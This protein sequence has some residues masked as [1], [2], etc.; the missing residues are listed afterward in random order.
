[1]EGE[2]EKPVVYSKQYISDTDL[3]YNCGLETFG[4]TQAQLMKTSLI[5]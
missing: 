4:E 5:K 3:I 1:M 2:E